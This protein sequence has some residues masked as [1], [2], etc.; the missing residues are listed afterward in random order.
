MQMKTV[1]VVGLGYVG[2]PLAV[3]WGRAGFSVLGID[4]DEG[5]VGQLREGKS[6]IGDVPDSDVAELVNS[7]R[8]SVANDYGMLPSADI[9]SVCVPTPIALAKTPD[10][11][12]VIDAARGIAGYLRPGQLVILE[13]TTYPGTTEEVV[14]PILERSGLKVGADFYLAFAPERINPGD[15]KNTLAN[16]PRVVGGVTPACSEAAKTALSC[17]APKVHVVGSPKAAEMTKL[18]ENIFRSV[19]VAMANELALL[20]ERMSIDVWEVIEAASSKPFGFMPF[21]PGAGVGG[22]CIPVDPYYLSW[23][24]REYDF[25]TRFIDLASQ[26][27]LSMPYHVVERVAEALN[28]QGKSLA[29]S[30]ILILGVAFKKDVD[31]ARNS[32]AEKVIELLARRGAHVCYNDPFVPHFNVDGSPFIEGH[33]SL[34]STSLSDEGISRS[35]CTIIV[36]GHTQYDYERLAE[37]APLI[38]DCCNATRNIKSRRGNVVRVGSPNGNGSANT[39][40]FR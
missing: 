13:S 30:R 15:R 11:T 12:H 35:D 40:G 8:L 6:P 31:D 36:T 27:N 1:C 26:V 19:N 32:P 4:L 16:T 18:W 10:L 28:S 37:L 34:D 9:I 7:G 38:V 23:K 29:G 5:K 21:Y 22:H 24:A 25:Y 2:L 3:A 20:C 33:L 39:K 17:I 14:L